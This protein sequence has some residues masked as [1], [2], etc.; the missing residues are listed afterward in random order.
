MVR[1]TI[2]LPADLVERLKIEAARRRVS[3]ATVIREALEAKVD[4]QRP[5]LHFLGVGDSGHADT[6]RKSADDRP[7][8]RDWR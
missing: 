2:S 3:M 1:T 7:G 8:I 5:K 6:A 4:T